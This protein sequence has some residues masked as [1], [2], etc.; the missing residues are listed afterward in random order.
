MSAY[1]DALHLDSKAA[2]QRLR[3]AAELL[4]TGEG[5]VVLEGSLALRPGAGRITCEVIDDCLE[6]QRSPSEYEA[7]VA[8][9]KIL[10]HGSKLAPF[11]SLDRLDWIVVQDYGTGTTQVW[12]AV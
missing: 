12:P 6:R 10:L 1:R 7:L 4:R 9:A 2:E 11:V 8:A 5:V 3:V